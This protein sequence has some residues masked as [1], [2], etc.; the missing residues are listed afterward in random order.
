[1]KE[2]Q[3]RYHEFINRVQEEAEFGSKEEAVQ[4]TEAALTTLGERLYRTDR[5]DLAAQLPKQL[6]EYL[7]K[8]SDAGSTRQDAQHFSLEAFY[9]RVGARSGVRY[10]PAVKE[11]QAV[12]AILEEAISPGM[13]K[14]VL[15]SLPDEF[16]EL[17]GQ[18][19]DRPA[20]P[21]AVWR[22]N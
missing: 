8:T 20:S 6:K 7:H 14:A 17:F 5:D 21:S 12:M 19:P 11:A 2:I 3:M 9:N 18:K 15:S 10:S 4:A 22:P 13:L 16:A 1:L